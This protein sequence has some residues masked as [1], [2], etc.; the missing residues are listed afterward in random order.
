ML[1]R[2]KNL[3]L[4]CKSKPFAGNKGEFLREKIDQDHHG[5]GQEVD[6]ADEFPFKLGIGHEVDLFSHF[7]GRC[8]VMD[9]LYYV[10]GGRMVMSGHLAFLEAVVRWGAG[11]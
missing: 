8:I 2:S 4:L 10:V 5:N 11:E 7:G 9:F 1:V 3:S 6:L